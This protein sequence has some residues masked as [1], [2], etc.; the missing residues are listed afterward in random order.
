MNILQKETIGVATLGAALACALTGHSVTAQD[1]ASLPPTSDATELV[2]LVEDAGQALATVPEGLSEPTYWMEVPGAGTSERRCVEVP[3]P[4]PVR[5]GEFRLTYMPV[6]PQAGRPHKI[7]WSPTDGSPSMSLQ[8]RGRLV[9]D[10]ESALALRTS[11]IARTT[12]A[13]DDTWYFFPS[14]IEFPAS[15][16]WVVVATSGANWGCFIF[17]VTAPGAPVP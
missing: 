15:G 17:D 7:A 16:E 12:G 11:R 6:R 13:D 2:A 1:F 8:V 4:G 5:S 10:S 9:S 3:T 14:M